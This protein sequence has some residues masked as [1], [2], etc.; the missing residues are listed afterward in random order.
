M[1]R[2]DECDDID[3]D[4]W[5]PRCSNCGQFNGSMK[6]FCRCKA[7]ELEEA[8]RT[9]D[10]L[11]RVRHHLDVEEDNFFPA[12]REVPS[13]VWTEM[14]NEQQRIAD[15][16]AAHPEFPW[17]DGRYRC[18]VHSVVAGTA[19]TSGRPQLV[20]D[21]SFPD[22]DNRLLRHYTTLT[23]VNGTCKYTLLALNALGCTDLSVI[24]DLPSLVGRTATA[25]LKI[26]EF[27]GKPNALVQRLH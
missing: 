13:T 8:N 25:E 24:A 16:L 1:L 9:I 5:T 7:A 21:L 14:R 10:R 26:S 11:S 2:T 22:Y 6:N 18:S 27:R 12:T 4:D 23:I 20:W 15:L 3:A 19:K 17:R